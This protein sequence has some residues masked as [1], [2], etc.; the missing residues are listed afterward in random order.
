MEE[1]KILRKATFFIRMGEYAPKG[2]NWYVSLIKGE[3]T[4]SFLW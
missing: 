1:R 3:Y 4:L 2:R